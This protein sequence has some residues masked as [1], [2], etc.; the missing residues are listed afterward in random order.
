MVGNLTCAPG[1][2]HGHSRGK[3]VDAGQP[4]GTSAE[5][6]AREIVSG[7]DAVSLC[8]TGRDDHAFRMNVM[9]TSLGDKGHER[10]LVHADRGCALENRDLAALAYL[11]VELV[12]PTACG[13]R[14]DCLADRA[15]VGKQHRCPPL[16]GG[17]RG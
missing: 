17:E 3:S 5:P 10:S 7:E 4:G 11:S 14:R 12:D 8:R 2:H 9:D 15:L 6:D 16:G 1:E 13:A